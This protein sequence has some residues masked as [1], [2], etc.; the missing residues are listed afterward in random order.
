MLISL[1]VAFPVR[2]LYISSVMLSGVIIGC[3][4][5]KYKDEPCCTYFNS[6]K[7]VKT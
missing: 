4:Y 5:L 3:F 7:Y 1:S 2:Y 6:E